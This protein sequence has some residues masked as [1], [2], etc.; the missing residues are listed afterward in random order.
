MFLDLGGGKAVGE[1]I[2]VGLR[3]LMVALCGM[4]R[5]LRPVNA[6]KLRSEWNN[7]A[8]RRE[9]VSRGSAEL[10]SVGFLQA[11]LSL[12]SSCSSWGREGAGLG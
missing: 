6:R 11:R 5:K 1:G 12:G 10:S 2:A 7:W 9:T 4:V 8:S 3:L